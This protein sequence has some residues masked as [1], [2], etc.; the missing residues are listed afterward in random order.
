M[1]DASFESEVV[2]NVEAR[3]VFVVE[4][5][6]FD[7]KVELGESSRRATKQSDVGRV[8]AIGEVDVE[9]ERSDSVEAKWGQGP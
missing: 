3:G 9:E 2:G 6:A 4:V 7:A 8:L 5:A 1:K